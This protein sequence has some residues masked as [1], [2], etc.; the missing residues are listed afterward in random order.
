MRPS[1]HRDITEAYRTLVIL[2]EVHH[3]GDA[4]SW[5]DGI[6]EAFER[7]TR[8]LVADGNAV[9]LRHRAHPVRDLPA[10]R[11]RHPHLAHRLQLRLRPR[12]RR[13]RRAPGASSWS[14][15]AT[16]AGAPRPA[17]RWRRGSARATP[18]TSPR[19]RG[20]PRSTRRGEWIPA[21]LQRRRPAP[22]RGAQ[23][24][25]GCRRPR[26]RDRPLHRARLRRPP[27]AD[28]AASRSRSCSPTRRRRAT[29]SRSSRTATS[30][31]MVAVRMVSEGVDVPRLAVG[32]YATSASTPLFFAQAIGRFVR[33]RRRGETASV[34]LP[35][36][37]MPDGA[38]RTPLELERDHALDRV[39]RRRTPRA[40]STTPKTPWWPRR[41]ATRRRRRR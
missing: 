22:H 3:G 2:D 26:H 9:P 32:V 41:T 33:A 28:H 14:T 37:P 40:T 29:G 23:L 30:R 11:A 17:T 16:C 7:A 18:K 19:R 1:L 5:G 4:L 12:A 39:T 21:V 25:P 20:A 13:R 8:R 31:W 27:A 6:R 15:P 24:D 35:N 38:R 34:F 10:R 36:V